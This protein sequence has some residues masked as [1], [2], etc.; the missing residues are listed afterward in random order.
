MP[1]NFITS[2]IEISDVTFFN[3]LSQ[4]SLT[5][6]LNS[7]W[8]S[9]KDAGYLGRFPAMSAPALAKLANLRRYFTDIYST[10]LSSQSSL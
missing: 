3:P 5:N 6:L 2:S 8:L 7:S 4:M 1:Y 9:S 10:F